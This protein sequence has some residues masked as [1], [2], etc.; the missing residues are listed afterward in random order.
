MIAFV[1]LRV[2][3]IL[4]LVAA[5]AFFAAAEFALVSVRDT[6]IQQLIEARRIGARIVQKLHR[7]LDEVVNGVQL[8]ITVTSLTLGWVGEPLLA[9]MVEG[10]I[11]RIPHA[12]LYS[13]GIAIVIAFALITFLHVILGELVPKS[14]ALQRA[15]Q[16]ALAVA[17]PMDVFL[18]V[19]RPFLFVMSRAAGVVLRIFG[20]RKIRQGPIH[21]PDELKLIVTASRQ[22]GQI[23]PFQ[24]EVIHQALELEN[25]TVREVMVPRPDIFSLPGDLTLEEAL[26]RVVEEQHSRIS[27]YDPQRGP[28]HIIGVL[29]AK[30]LMRWTR[31][32]YTANPMQPVLPRITNMKISQIMHDVL[33]VPETKVLT[34][35]LE[36][37]KQRKRHLAVVV[38]E[39]GSTA[40]VITVEDILEQLVGEIEDEFDVVPPQHA[41]LEGKT[42]LVL[43]GSASIRDLESQHDLLLPRDAGFETLAGFVLSRLQR[44]PSIG[45]TF[46]YEGHRFTV[47]EMEGHRIARVK[48]EKLEPARLGQVGD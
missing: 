45:D 4:L 43:E 10:S 26:G 44:V 46:D 34:E 20:S 24:E 42:A 5:N 30:D 15:E 11:G 28:E 41:A 12:A 21:S 32:R 33:V 18:T 39:F 27:V 16:V 31:L 36:E 14:L 1:L 47:A 37:F 17:G 6:R 48:I 3:L 13:H 7:N 22:F 40:G 9:R 2:F 35:L 19:S 23:P 38:D 29:Y 25:I 8:G